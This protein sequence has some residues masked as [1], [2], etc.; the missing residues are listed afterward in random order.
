MND[1]N[2]NSER[3]YRRAS[4]RLGTDN[5]ACC[6]CGENN[7]HCLELHHLPGHAFGDEKAIVCRN[8]HRKMSDDQKDHP[9][10]LGSSPSMLERI[11][12]FLLGLADLFKLL[13]RSL[14]EYGRYL[15]NLAALEM[16][17]E[18]GGCK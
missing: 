13:S 8:C 4:Q 15:I 6:I 14:T 16:A 9:E 12:H 10:S 3:R 2:A 18:I 5:P 7:P 11:G 1:G 17:A